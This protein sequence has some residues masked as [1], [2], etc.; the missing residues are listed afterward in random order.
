MVVALKAQTGGSVYLLAEGAGRGLGIWE[1]LA[2]QDKES[3]TCVAYVPLRNRD[4]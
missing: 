4:C 3:S 1:V 2:D